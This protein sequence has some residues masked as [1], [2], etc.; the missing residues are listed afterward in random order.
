MPA[1][2]GYGDVDDGLAGLARRTRKEI[3]IDYPGKSKEPMALN[4][5]PFHKSYRTIES[6]PAGNIPQPD[7][8]GWMP[9]NGAAELPEK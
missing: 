2:L 1:R 3:P 4:H 9:V 7:L 6:G 8:S 5:R